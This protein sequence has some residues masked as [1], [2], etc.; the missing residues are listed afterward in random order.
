MAHVPLAALVEDSGEESALAGELEHGGLI[1]V[2]TVQRIACD[3]TVVVALDDDLGHTMYEGRAQRFATDTQ[4][5]EVM[6]RDRQCRF[7]GCTNVTFT[8]VHHVVAW[9]SGGRTDL[10]NL[11]LLCLYHHH[12]GA[13]PRGGPCRATPT[14]S[15]PSSARAAGS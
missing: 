7:P 6:R 10:D 14:R 8:N 3:A 11:A 5:R 15:S 13:Q 9:K 1:D 12:T 2:E 4:R